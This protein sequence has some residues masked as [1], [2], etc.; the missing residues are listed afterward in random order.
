[1]SKFLLTPLSKYQNF[2]ILISRLIIGAAFAYVH[3]WK[4]IVGGSEMWTNLGG[5]MKSIGINFLPVFWGFMA[6]FVEFF[7]GIFIAV[8]LFFRPSAI[9]IFITML[10]ASAFHLNNGDPIG[11]VVYPLEIAALMFL[12]I[13]TGPGKYSLDKIFF[14]KFRSAALR[15]ESV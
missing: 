6:S 7:G 9:L 11:K 3:G 4:K 14:K 8:G 10:V 12:L 5:A 15:F 1:M 13:Y 2:T